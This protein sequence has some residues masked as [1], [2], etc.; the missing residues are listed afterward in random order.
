[1][2]TIAERDAVRIVALTGSAEDHLVRPVAERL[3]R[4]GD[5]GTV[6]DIADRLGGVGHHYTVECRDADGRLIWLAVFA[7]HELAL[8]S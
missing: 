2:R 6:V 7:A 1:M 8:V 5:L 4:V 3:P